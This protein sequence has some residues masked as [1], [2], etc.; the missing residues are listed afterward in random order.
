ML[1]MRARTSRSLWSWQE[2]RVLDRF[3]RALAAGEYRSA[4]T[5]ARACQV[6]LDELR[7]KHPDAPWAISQRTLIGIAT[8]IR[9]R[10][11]AMGA[12]WPG[13]RLLPE[14]Q[15]TA[16]R[17]A[18]AFLRGEYP[19]VR[20]A[21]RACHQEV[22]Q[23]Q[24]GS[25]GRLRFRVRRPYFGVYDAVLESV[26]K[27]GWSEPDGHWSERERQ[28][29]QR[30]ARGLLSGRY[31]TAAD[32]THACRQ[33]FDRLRN[34]RP[35]P[36]WLAARRKDLGIWIAVTRAA[37]Q[38]GWSGRECWSA[39]ATA[40]VGQLVRRVLAGS[41]PT[42]HQA[43]LEFL[44]EARRRHGQRGFRVRRTYRSVMWKMGERARLLGKGPEHLAW[45]SA[46][47]RLLDHCI[48]GMAAGRFGT[49]REA[50]QAFVSDPDRQRRERDG[51][52]PRRAFDAAMHRLRQRTD[53]RGQKSTRRWS[54]GEKGLAKKWGRWYVRHRRAG[55]FWALGDAADGL[56]KELLKKG[57]DRTHTSC[58]RLVLRSR[59]VA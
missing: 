55:S 7:E 19:D 54:A 31:A 8:Q 14:E 23:A 5:A 51:E 53:L 17:Y 26:R 18:Q 22:N 21:A 48:Q 39:E 49:A 25:A 34:R 30:Y 43:T 32:A 10:T 33:H 28:T 42:L 40:L 58:L 45:T 4:R 59:P 57:Y 41:C 46:E 12:R 13:S 38:L 24:F 9:Q 47:D 29:A 6:E 36:K 2:E 20:A 56:R 50:A 11:K 1:G 44:R 16:E 52:W 37:H 27:T 3:A 35:A 15:E